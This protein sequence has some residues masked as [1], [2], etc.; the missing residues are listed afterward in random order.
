M[1]GS[2]REGDSF[3]SQ[4]DHLS[5]KSKCVFEEKRPVSQSRR[6]KKTRETFLQVV[7][8]PAERGLGSVNHLA[9]RPSAKEAV[10]FL[11]L[12][13]KKRC[14]SMVVEITISRKYIYIFFVSQ[15]EPPGA[16]E[17]YGPA[18]GL[19]LDSEASA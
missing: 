9:A 6:A 11:P 5:A 17:Q 12:G 2:W 10:T 3:A 18:S 19:R 1:C 14:I 4:T 15:T 16:D 13:K 7:L 8:R